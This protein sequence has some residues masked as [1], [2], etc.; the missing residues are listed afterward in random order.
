MANKTTGKK[1][2]NDNKAKPKPRSKG[3]KM[4]MQH[5]GGCPA[6]CRNYC[7]LLG[8]PRTAPLVPMPVGSQA[9]ARFRVV[10]RYS[11]TVPSAT[12][13]IDGSATTGATPAPNF[14][15]SADPYRGTCNAIC[16]T[17]AQSAIVAGDT[18]ATS[19]GFTSGKGQIFTSW[20]STPPGLNV[21]K[22]R[23]SAACTRL[24]YTGKDS[25]MAGLH[26]AGCGS[27][28]TT[29]GLA[30]RAADAT[31]TVI[32]ATANSTTRADH[33]VPHV[34][35]NN[36]ISQFSVGRE[37]NVEA[38]LDLPHT[39]VSGYLTGYY[40]AHVDGTGVDIGNTDRPIL[41]LVGT[42]VTPGTTY[43]VETTV[44]YEWI[45]AL[46]GDMASVDTDS[47]KVMGNTTWDM[48]KTWTQRLGV[49]W[50]HVYKAAKFT[51]QALL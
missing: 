45:A 26:G 22:V 13:R 11:F 3:S 9:Q 49:D 36:L 50:G 37:P 46:T 18:T 19:A 40:S 34:T 12:V 47:P 27:Q 29:T 41:Q 4:D 7:R 6:E 1:S 33:A 28:V 20:L 38:C 8:N 30:I 5:G 48:I 10:S 32:S 43:M 31:W 15:V 24:T 39:S 21:G 44:V 16:Y 14:I 17:S 51:A 23:I 25:D 2:K 35:P 42:G